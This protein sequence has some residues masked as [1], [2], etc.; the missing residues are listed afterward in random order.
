MDET[1]ASVIESTR[2]LTSES[3]FSSIFTVANSVCEC[4]PSADDGAKWPLASLGGCT[5]VRGTGKHSR[6]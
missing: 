3:I 1:F 2:Y 6:L 4:V 5:R